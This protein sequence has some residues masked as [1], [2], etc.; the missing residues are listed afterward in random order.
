MNR[1]HSSTILSTNCIELVIMPK[2][3]SFKTTVYQ[4]LSITILS[5][6]IHNKLPFFL[7][8]LVIPVAITNRILHTT[9]NKTFLENRNNR[10]K[11]CVN[12]WNDRIVFVWILSVLKQIYVY[13][14]QFALEYAKIN[15]CEI[16]PFQFLFIT[17]CKN[18]SISNAYNI[19]L[20]FSSIS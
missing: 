9:Q 8:I 5:N 20:L 10:I 11:H 17:I 19:D 6:G 13:L 7:H 1:N 15:P 12:Q 14:V 18:D 3:H 2:N 4:S 16:S